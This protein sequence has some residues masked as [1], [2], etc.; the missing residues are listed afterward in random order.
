MHE[1]NASA[2]HEPNASALAARDRYN[3]ARVYMEYKA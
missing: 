2:M 1:P 3:I